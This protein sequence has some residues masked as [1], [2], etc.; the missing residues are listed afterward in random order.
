MGSANSVVSNQI[1]KPL[2]VLT[3]NNADTVYAYYNNQY[4]IAPWG[5]ARVEAGADAWGLKVGIVYGVSEDGG[6]LLYRRWFCA[7]G[8]TLN[9]HSI[10]YDQIEADGCEHLGTGDIAADADE[11]TGVTEWLGVGLEAAAAAGGFYVV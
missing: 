4:K 6:R 7:N 5:E 1:D 10:Y 8:S 3:F 9:V 11:M 2:A